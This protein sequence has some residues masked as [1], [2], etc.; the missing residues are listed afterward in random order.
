LA[1]LKRATSQS[2]AYRP[3]ANRALKMSRGCAIDVDWG[4][5]HTRSGSSRRCGSGI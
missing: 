4:R 1:G 2:I 3:V 5:L